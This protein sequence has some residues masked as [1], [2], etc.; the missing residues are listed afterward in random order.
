MENLQSKV[1]N[2]VFT[3]LSQA[4]QTPESGRLEFHSILFDFIPF[5]DS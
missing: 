3:K 2:E 5:Y 1:F 4:P